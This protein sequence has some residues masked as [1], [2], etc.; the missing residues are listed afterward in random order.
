MIEKGDNTGGTTQHGVDSRL[1]LHLLFCLD[2]SILNLVVTHLEV[3]VAEPV[4]VVLIGVVFLIG[5]I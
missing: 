1:T 2:E 3:L 5:Q 4:F